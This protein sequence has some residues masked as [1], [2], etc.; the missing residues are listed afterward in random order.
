MP[1]GCSSRIACG[2]RR[3]RHHRHPAADIDQVAQDV[4][5]HP[6]IERHH[7]RA[8]PSGCYQL[9]LLMLP[10]VTGSS[11]GTQEG[12]VQAGSQV[13]LCGHDLDASR[14]RPTRPGLARALATRLASSRSVVERIPFIAPRSRVQPHQGAGVDSLDADDAVLLEETRKRPARSAVT[15]PRS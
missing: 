2:G 14:S 9:E 15:D 3:A 6:E 4:P 11:G 8:L 13:P 12:A 7:V 1:S 5:L 10:A